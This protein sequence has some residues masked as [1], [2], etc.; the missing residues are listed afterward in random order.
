MSKKQIVLAV[1]GL[2]GHSG[3]FDNLKTELIKYDI[4]FYAYD[5]PG[6]GQNHALGKLSSHYTRG[7][8]DSFQEW[9]DFVSKKYYELSSKYPDSKIAILGHSL[10]A[11]LVSNIKLRPQDSLILSVPGYKGSAKTFNP[12]FVM[13]T[14]S[15]YLIDKCLLARDV[16]V[17]M[18]VSEKMQETPAM[19]DPLR[20]SS[21][22]QTLLF[23]ILRLG[24]FTK[25]N[26]KNIYAPV[27]LVQMKDD[28]V[29]DN[30]TQNN[31]FE[32][33]PSK[34]KTMKVY[35]GADHDWIWY[36]IREEIAFGIAIWLKSL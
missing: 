29:V 30:E 4:D 25:S 20:V 5:L 3:W 12:F 19:K 32:Q 28:Q 33:I 34:N 6:F 21:V 10:G 23:E 31:F 27:L 16:Y 13:S 8:I 15:K 14:M 9:L 7:H 18:P 24:K 2:G 1:H 17:E 35:A 36:P 26:L 22:T 11:V